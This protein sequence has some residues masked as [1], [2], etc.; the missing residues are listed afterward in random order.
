MGAIY[1]EW[2]Y[3]ASPRMRVQGS[4]NV[5]VNGTSVSINGSL[6][7]SLK[8][9]YWG[10]YGYTITGWV[11]V[12]GSNW[13]SFTVGGI[14]G[15]GSWNCS[16][17]LG[18][19]NHTVRIR[20]SCGDSRCS[21]R[22]F[23]VVVY[24]EGFTTSD[25]SRPATNN[26]IGAIHTNLGSVNQ[27]TVTEYND[28]RVRWDWSG[29]SNGYPSSNYISTHNVDCYPSNNSGSAYSVSATQNYGRMSWINMSTI[30]SQY[31]LKIG[32]TL[33][34]WVN[35][36]TQG[37]TWLGRVYC[38]AVR[39]IPHVPTCSNITISNRSTTSATL[40]GTFDDK[41]GTID[42]YTFGYRK[43]GD[44]NWSDREVTSNSRSLTGLTPNTRY[45]V[46]ARAH[47]ETGWGSYK[48]GIYFWTKPLANKPTVACTARGSTT[49]TAVVT[50]NATNYP[51][52]NLYDLNYKKSSDSSWINKADQSSNSF[53]LT[54]LSPN[55][56]YDIRG[57][58]RTGTGGDGST[59]WS[60]WSNTVSF[61]T[62]PQ[63]GTA[64]AQCVRNNTTN[65]LN[66]KVNTAGTYAPAVNRYQIRYRLSG[67]STWTTMTDSANQT[68]TIS[69]LTTGST[70]EIQVRARTSTGLDGTTAWSNWSSSISIRVVKKST[71]TDIEFLS[72]T[73][74]SV[75][76]RVSYTNGYPNANRIYYALVPAGSTIPTDPGR[77]SNMYVATSSSPTT[78][79]INRDY[80]GNALAINR[81]YV[82]FII[83]NQYKSGSEWYT[84]GLDL[85]SDTSELVISTSVNVGTMTNVKC[86]RNNTY[87]SLTIHA[88]NSGNWTVYAGWEYRYKKSSDSS[89]DLYWSDYDKNDKTISSLEPG[90]TYNIQIRGTTGSV[91]DSAIYY[92]DIYELTIRVVKKPQMTLEIYHIRKNEIGIKGKITDTGYPDVT[93]LQWIYKSPSY[94]TLSY[95]P[96]TEVIANT[97]NFSGTI[98]PIQNYVFTG[99]YNT[100]KYNIVAALT[101]YKSPSEWYTAGLDHRIDFGINDIELAMYNTRTSRLKGYS[102]NWK[103]VNY[104]KSWDGSSWK[105]G[106]TDKNSESPLPIQQIWGNIRYGNPDLLANF[107]TNSSANLEKLNIWYPGVDPVRFK[108]SSEEGN[109]YGG[110]LFPDSIEIDFTSLKSEGNVTFNTS[111]YT[112]QTSGNSFSMKLNSNG[113]VSSESLMSL[114][115]PLPSNQQ[116][117]QVYVEY[118]QNIIPYN[119]DSADRSSLIGRYSLNGDYQSGNNNIRF[120]NFTTTQT[121]FLAAY[122]IQL[123]KD[124]GYSLIRLE[125]Y[126]GTSHPS[127]SK[128]TKAGTIFNISNFKIYYTKL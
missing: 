82:G 63:A 38:G 68:Q 9:G 31:G 53:S 83:V 14:G 60:S 79:T 7:N 96:N 110:N 119:S 4:C 2:H 93:K 34:C 47:N 109:A 76:I 117:D 15:T 50:K 22:L 62:K 8:P 3:S 52:I 95:S 91:S 105:N 92:S 72:N 88:E 101:H 48:S 64:S 89:Y 125:F 102:S 97:V 94:I 42:K 80:Q 1:S 123:Y 124:D 106:G 73:I 74:D 90:E 11:D 18:A 65:S 116:I 24:S 13:Q 67:S 51:N 87:N 84:A 32:D 118:C 120:I 69:G 128:M 40:S 29:E 66:I 43:V 25:P 49:A 33:Y 30:M 19:G 108:S 41:G 113:S 45:E 121:R 100:A 59:A 56:K 54:G 55:T 70:Y 44:S 104:I 61:F 28:G 126:N 5:N 27:G 98:N 10:Y 12:D 99:L 17:T 86:V 112:V 16:G 26:N 23:N 122:P 75:T 46:R 21:A 85:N 35:T 103:D 111:R 39:I 114:I 6:T 107:N 115:V 78:I 81:K 77:I 71:I 57:R 127:F 58:T 36:K 20:I 37:G